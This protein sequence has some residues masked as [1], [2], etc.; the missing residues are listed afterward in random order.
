M[1]SAAALI[2]AS[3]QAED[4][5]AD[6]A[7]I[8]RNASSA[9]SPAS[10]CVFKRDVNSGKDSNER[11]AATAQADCLL[12]KVERAGSLRIIVGINY[13]EL[14]PTASAEHIAC[15]TA[16]LR[17]AQDE[18]LHRAGVVPSVPVSRFSLVPAFTITAETALIRNLLADPNVVTIEEDAVGSVF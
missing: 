4:V 10:R 12:Q 16:G 8:Y 17:A 1:S 7:S 14:P 9:A 5:F 2:V 15:H 6:P 11:V 18:A 3:G 13:P